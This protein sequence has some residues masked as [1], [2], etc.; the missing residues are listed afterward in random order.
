MVACH[1]G[2][3]ASQA[4]P[5]AVQNTQGAG[6]GRLLHIPRRG[7]LWRSL[8]SVAAALRAIQV[9]SGFRRTA[10]HHRRGLD[11]WIG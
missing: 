6:S 1:T 2:V 8:T 9:G 5:E 4:I 11:E 10:D 3:T 7:E